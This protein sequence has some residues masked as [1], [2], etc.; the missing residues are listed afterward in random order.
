MQKEIETQVRV[1]YAETD[2]SGIAYN[3]E[4]LVWFEVARGE[5]FWQQG[6]DY[7]RDIEARGFHWPLSEAGLRFHAAAYY[8][9][10]LTVRAWVDEIKS[11]A[12]TIRY[13]ITRD[14]QKLCTGFT[15]HVN[16]NDRGHPVPFSPEIL[17]MI[18]SGPAEASS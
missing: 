4:Y 14:G 10:L 2:A 7:R 17:A 1:R 18:R 5:I 9:D 12:L 6:L 11:R 13:E 15:T 8:G 3:A 16:V